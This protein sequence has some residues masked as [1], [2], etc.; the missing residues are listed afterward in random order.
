[1]TGVA[2]QEMRN[3]LKKLTKE[4]TKGDM[5]ELRKRFRRPLTKWL[6]EKNTTSL[7]PCLIATRR[8]VQASGTSTT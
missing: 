8:T 2:N 3:H 5:W 4:V 6:K 1:M 7:G